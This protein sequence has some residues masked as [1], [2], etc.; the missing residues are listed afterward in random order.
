MTTW[1][2]KSK[3]ILA[4]SKVLSII[5][6][7]HGMFQTDGIR[8]VLQAIIMGLQVHQSLLV[9]HHQRPHL[10]QV[11]KL[12]LVLEEIHWCV[13]TTEMVQSIIQKVVTIGVTAVRIVH[14]SNRQL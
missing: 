1:V 8:A 3:I 11:V 12:M 9:L 13:V 5:P 6:L 2:N 14:I 10:T 4:I 7:Y